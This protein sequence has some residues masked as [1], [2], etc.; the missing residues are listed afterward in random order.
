MQPAT[1]H[2]RRAQLEGYFDRTAAQ[3]WERLTSTAPVGRVRATVRAGRDA[4]RDIL[5]SWLPEDLSG[6]TL[7]DAGCGTGAL[8]VCAAQRG[9]D[10][11]GVDLSPTLLDLARQRLPEITAPGKVTLRAGDMLEPA[12]GEFDHVVA[13]DSLIHYDSTHILAA[14]RNLAVRCTTSICFTMAPRTPALA[15]MH[16]VGRL[17]PHSDHKAPA[18]IP[19]AEQR[20]RD[21]IEQDD[22]LKG[23]RLTRTERVSTGF[24]KSQAYLLER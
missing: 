19:I 18:I 17:I 4:M 10:V 22:T 5:L 8:S 14:L 13:M 16:A 11:L 7:L 1:Y 20:L 12:L 2:E 3:N 21:L 23:W 24:Y 9:A 6:R 15:L